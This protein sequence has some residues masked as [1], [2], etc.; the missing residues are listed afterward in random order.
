MK[1]AFLGTA[2]FAVPSLD[3]LVSA[4]HQAVA[5]ITRPDRPSGRG[6]RLS[7]APV[8]ARAR[9]LGL[10]I[11]Q[12]ESLSHPEEIAYL[13][14]IAPGLIVSAA[15]GRLI[16]SAYL[17]AAAH[18]GINLHPSLLPRWR[19]AAPIAWALIA[20]DRETGVT[21]HRLVDRLD[22]GEIFA[23]E[24]FPITPD[25]D[26]LTLAARLSPE[27]ARLLRAVVDQIENGRAAPFP[28]DDSR[29]TLAPKLSK[30]DGLIDWAQPAETIHNRVRGFVPWPGSFTHLDRAG[31]RRL[32]KIHAA[33]VVSAGSGEP[34]T[35]LEAAEERLV[36][37]T[38]EGAL[39]I[40]RL[41]AEG[42]KAMAAGE[43]LRGFRLAAGERIG[44]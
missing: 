40:L 4:G 7:E 28:Q 5:V 24:A 27:G 31:C 12:P 1:I 20:G 33:R 19:G 15:Y 8:K 26:G 38:G 2:D 16:P 34:G 44:L 41:Q 14:E 35:I 36:I 17:A 25:D 39:L 43:F 42:G 10:S 22:A 21:V 9:E 37:A 11:R 32:I 30:D 18:G 3:A 13:R 23:Q 29:A 6:R